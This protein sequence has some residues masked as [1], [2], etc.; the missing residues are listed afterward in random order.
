MEPRWTVSMPQLGCF[1][2]QRRDSSDSADI[3]QGLHAC[4]SVIRTSKWIGFLFMNDP[5]MPAGSQYESTKASAAN[6]HFSG[7][8]RN[9]AEKIFI[10]LEHEK[11]GYGKESP[12]EHSNQCR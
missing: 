1:A 12:G 5:K 4:A 10:S 9:A 2:P 3:G 6:V 8:K 11:S 7:A